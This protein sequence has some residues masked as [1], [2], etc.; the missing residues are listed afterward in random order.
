MPG[1]LFEHTTLVSIPGMSVT[2]CETHYIIQHLL[3][4]TSLPV[5]RITVDV[6]VSAVDS[7]DFG[8]ITTR[9]TESYN[10]SISE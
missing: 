4:V 2:N 9:F 7:A 6:E 10:S 8:R 1:L 5:L 3:T